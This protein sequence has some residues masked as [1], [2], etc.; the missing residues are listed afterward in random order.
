MG[1]DGTHVIEPSK[2]FDYLLSP[3]HPTGHDKAAFFGAF[4]SPPPLP[5]GSQTRWRGMRARETS[6]G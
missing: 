6:P 3:T 4:G 5:G 2:L 1:L